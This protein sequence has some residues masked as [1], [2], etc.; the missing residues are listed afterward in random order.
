MNFTLS[1]GLLPALKSFLSPFGSSDFVFCNATQSSG[2]MLFFLEDRGVTGCFV[3]PVV[4][5]GDVDDFFLSSATLSSLIQSAISADVDLICEVTSGSIR[6]TIDSTDIDLSLPFVEKDTEESFFLPDIPESIMVSIDMERFQGI[7]SALTVQQKR[8]Y[9]TPVMEFGR[10]CKYGTNS[11]M[12]CLEVP[13][14]AFIGDVSVTSDF[15]KFFTVVGKIKGDKRTVFKTADFFGVGLGNF[16]YYT[17][18][19][20]Q[21][22]SDLSQ[23]D[24]QTVYV[25]LDLRKEEVSR[26]SEILSRLEIPVSDFDNPIIL[27]SFKDRSNGSVLEMSVLDKSNRISKDES[28]LVSKVNLS[29]DMCFRVDFAGVNSSLRKVLSKESGV[30]ITIRDTVIIFSS[31][32]LKEYV[33]L[34]V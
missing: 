30:S 26:I 18:L 7:A 20:S 31:S 27:L 33:M 24:N 23:F 11:D 21:S 16:Y 1:K 10:L 5:E 17:P 22:F 14:L 32:L 3:F 19:L 34:Y 4:V 2:S 25:G 15:L 12:V 6:T 9:L 28:V 29:A 8:S 13:E